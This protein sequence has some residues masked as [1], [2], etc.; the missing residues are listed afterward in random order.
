MLASSWGS[1][2][3]QHASET[4]RGDRDIVR[5]SVAVSYSHFQYAIDALKQDLDFLRQLKAIDVDALTY[6]PED[7]RTQALAVAT[8]TTTYRGRQISARIEPERRVSNQAHTIGP[9]HITQGE[10]VLVTTP[11]M[12]FIEWEEHGPVGSYLRMSAVD[13]LC[14]IGDFV[15]YISQRGMD[16]T[17]TSEGTHPFTGAQGKTN[18]TDRA[19][20]LWLVELTDAPVELNRL[21]ERAGHDARSME[22]HG[23]TLLSK[24]GPLPSGVATGGA[25]PHRF[26][27]TITELA[28]G[29]QPS[30]FD[31][32]GSMT[33]GIFVESA[34]TSISACGGAARVHVEGHGWR[35]L[36]PQANQR[37]TWSALK[38]TLESTGDAEDWTRLREDFL[39]HASPQ[40]Q[41]LVAEH[42]AQTVLSAEVIAHLQTMT[43]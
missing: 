13:R 6:A 15:F 33:E 35:W 19:D 31:Q 4:F 40:E 38:E 27:N 12:S 41:A 7:L 37:Y 14:L 9:V 5:D 42:F 36:F 24:G 23:M 2:G 17:R 16:G 25:D 10:S 43:R 22:S 11:M 34:S 32:Y 1:R 26:Y 30:N 8:Q 39:P 18:H 20:E 3:L 28:K 21:R 29:T